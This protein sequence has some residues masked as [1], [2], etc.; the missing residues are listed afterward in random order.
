MAGGTGNECITHIWWTNQGQSG[1]F[2]RDQ[3][4]AYIKANGNGAVCCVN[5]GGASWVRV[6]RKGTVEY[7]QAYADGHWT[8]NLLALPVR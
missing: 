3:I 4:V 6:N 7:P 5:A 8:D 2:S 1:C